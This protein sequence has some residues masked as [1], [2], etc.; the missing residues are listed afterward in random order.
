MVGGRQ[1]TVAAALVAA[2]AA[3]S[4]KRDNPIYCEA[5]AECESG[6]VCD[7]DR[8][9]CIFDGRDA[10]WNGEGC[11]DST[12]CPATLP[13]CSPE[14]E[15][16]G[17]ELG[18]TGDADCAA[19]DPLLPTCR[20]D[21]RCVACLDSSACTE[22]L[23]AFCDAVT[24]QCRGCN[25]HDE[26]GSEVCNFGQ[27]CADASSIVYVDNVSGI[28]GAT[29]GTQAEPCATIAGT[30]G[31]LSKVGPGRRTVHIADGQGYTEALVLDGISVVLVGPGAVLQPIG[32]DQ[33]AIEAINGTSVTIDGLTVSGGDG[34]T[35]G[36][37]VRCSGDGTVVRIERAQLADNDD[38]GADV[39][40]GCDLRMDRT[41]VARNAGG[42]IRVAGDVYEITNSI[43]TGNGTSGASAVGG[44]RLAP[45]GT[46]GTQRLEFTT[47]TSNQVNAGAGGVACTDPLAI[48]SL[49]VRGNDGTEIGAMCSAT[50][51][52]IEGGATGEG[53]IDADPLFVA[54]DDLH[55][56]T[57]SPCIDTADPA[58]TLTLDIDGEV[59]PLGGGR[60]MGADEAE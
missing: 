40:A 50:Y 60:D 33:A 53:N 56:A 32:A 38:L 15:C 19:R 46:P 48:G 41:L 9:E 59:R 17:C 49:I 28:D 26:C 52:D 11:A 43:I 3:A 36:D 27:A 10:G 14:H 13:I 23:A 45:A 58:A 16:L 4:C 35:N 57:G 21:G 31:G 20:D 6:W 34:A 1:L 8:R 44:I 37:G 47:I 12:F 54:S 51:S 24:G 30:M 18:S 39:D 2:A 5:Q 29:C 7:T 55:L 22:P 25:S 42:G